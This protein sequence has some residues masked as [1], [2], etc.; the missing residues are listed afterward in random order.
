MKNLSWVFAGLALGSVTGLGCAG[1]LVDPDPEGT[2]KPPAQ[3]TILRLPTNAAP[4]FND[5]VAFYAKNSRDA[6]GIIYFKTPSGERG[7]KFARLRIE[8]GGLLTRPDGTPFGANDSVLI[9]MKVT[10][11]RLLLVEMSPAG[12]KFTANEPAELELEYEETDGDL[13]GDGDSG[14]DDDDE[15]EQ[16]L[17]IWR[18]ERP[19]DPFVKL[20]TVKT[21]GLREFEAK[22]SSFSRYAVAY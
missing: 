9:V 14:D 2:V 16:Q 7:E 17:A 13:D 4:L 19:G 20:G 3:L 12:L 6:E 8:E 22:L 10:D 15:I 11:P 21:E 18:Q 1:S 5:S